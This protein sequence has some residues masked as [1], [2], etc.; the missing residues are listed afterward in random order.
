MHLQHRGSQKM[1]RNI[2][3]YALS[4]LYVLSA[5]TII[6]DMLQFFAIAAVTVSVDD[7]GCL[8]V[9]S[10]SFTEHRD[11]VPL[12]NYRGHTICFV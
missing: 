5:A 3:F 8:T 12:C 11:C 1:A 9:F 10:I 4:V 2:L 6:V 7:H